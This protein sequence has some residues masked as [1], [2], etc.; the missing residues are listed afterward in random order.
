MSTDFSIFLLELG[1]TYAP[2][3]IWSPWTN[4]NVEIQNK[5]LNRYFR[6]YLSEAGNNWAKLACQLAFAHNISVNSSTVTTPYEVVS[7][8]K[9][10]IPISPKLDLV[11]DDN[12]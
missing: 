5:H 10:Q 12:D 1:I 6:C 4:G 9:A 3:T 8:F 7:G 2:R 11:R